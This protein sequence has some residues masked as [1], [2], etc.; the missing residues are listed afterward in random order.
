MGPY[1]KFCGTRCF[2]PTTQEDVV[3][4][5]LKATCDEGIAF[6]LMKAQEEQEKSENLNNKGN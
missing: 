4:R 5:D 3:K 1:C 2:V 6:D